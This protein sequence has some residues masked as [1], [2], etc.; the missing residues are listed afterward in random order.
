V[1]GAVVD[2]VLGGVL[3]AVAVVW[4]RAAC[5]ATMHPSRPAIAIDIPMPILE[6]S[7]LK[8]FSTC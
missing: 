5:A 8:G 4:A 2:A 6:R 1:L 7:C 3:G